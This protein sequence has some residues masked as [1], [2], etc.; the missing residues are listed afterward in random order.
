[1]KFFSWFVQKQLDFSFFFFKSQIVNT[2]PRA[3]LSIDSEN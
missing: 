1:M 2:L 3:R